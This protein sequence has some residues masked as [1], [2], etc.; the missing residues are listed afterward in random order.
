VSNLHADNKPELTLI[1]PVYEEEHNIVPFV[2]EVRKNISP[3]YIALIIYDHDHDSTLNKAEELTANDTNILFV[4]NIYG[5]GV[6]NAFKTGFVLAD[7][8]FIVPI[9]ADL[10]DMPETVNIMH[11]TI[12][13]GYDLVIASRYIKNGAKI[14]G[15]RRKYILSLLA[16]KSLNFFTGIPTHDFTNAFIMYRKKV[17]DNIEIK[18]TGGF[19][20]TMEII[21]KAYI[22]DYNIT[23]V[24][25]INRDRPAGK[26][27]FALWKWIG[28][29]LYWYFYIL[30][31][32]AGKSFRIS[33]NLKKIPK[34]E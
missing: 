1:I 26:S 22:L 20:I 6:I 15:S 2:E 32:S 21:A 4:K 11:T 25:T 14:G 27:K 3:S 12:Q 7:T 10:S 8:E 17:I 24:P 33:Q 28:K 30:L 13:Q 29:Y 34:E 9:M 16:N 23:E 5:T 31:Y 18:S 19:E